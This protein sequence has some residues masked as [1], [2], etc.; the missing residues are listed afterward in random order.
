MV[1]ILNPDFKIIRINPTFLKNDHM[2]Q[3]V[4]QYF[5]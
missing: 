5:G 1:F 3:F 4:E 2:N